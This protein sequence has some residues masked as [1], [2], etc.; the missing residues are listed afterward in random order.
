[1]S[2]C[3]R[4]VNL[5]KK[6]PQGSGRELHVLKGIDLSVERGEFLS[7]VGP[8]GAGKSTLLHLLGGLDEPTQG[9]VYVGEQ[10]I[11]KITRD[12]RAALRLKKIGFVFQFYH[13]LPEFNI[14]EN[15]ALPIYI[16][17]NLSKKEAQN[18]AVALLEEVGLAERL[19]H[20]PGELSGG[21]AQR[22]AIARALIL[23][24]EIILCDEPTGNLDTETGKKILELLIR[25]NREKGKT[26]IIVSH[27]ENIARCAK[28]I[29]RIR[30]GIIEG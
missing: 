15:V 26:F 10:N 21:E 1:M 23:E 9:T 11:F 2:S 16:A 13:L 12:H 28:R 4:C 5:H 7:I 18:K 6:F 14:L 24:P 19:R 29:L 25:A 17:R 8:S 27:D 3:L 22:V 20:R 30:D